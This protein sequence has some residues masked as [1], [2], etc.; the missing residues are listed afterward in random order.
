MSVDIAAQV[1]DLVKSQNPAAEAEVTVDTTDLALTRFANSFIHQ[2]VAEATTTVR[3]RL[4]ADGRTAA[5]TTTIVDTQG[6]HGLV[7]RTVAAARLAPPDPQW[8]GLAPP[9]STLPLPPVDEATAQA[10][11][12]ARAAR[13][14]DFVAAADGLE[15]AGYCSTLRLATAFANSAGMSAE[16]VSALAAMDAI[17]RAGIGRRG[18]PA[19]QLTTVRSGRRPAGRS[20][21]DQGP[22][23]PATAGAAARPLRGGARTDRGRRSAENLAFYAFNGKAVNERRSFIE[24]GDGPVRPGAVHRGR[25]VRP[26]R[27]RLRLRRGGH[28]QAAADV[29]RRRPQRRPW[30]TTAAARRRPVPPRPVT[31]CQARPRSERSRPTCTCCPPATRPTPGEVDGP[32]ADSSVAA[33]VGQVS[34]GLLVSD[35]WYTRVLDPRTLVITGL[36]RNGV[37]LIEDGV[38]TQPVQNLRF[39]QSY[40]QALA[41]GGVLGIGSHSVGLPSGWDVLAYP[42]TGAASGL[43]ELHRQRLGLRLLSGFAGRSLNRPPLALRAL[44]GSA[45]VCA[46]HCASAPGGDDP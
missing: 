21:G 25:S 44:T 22:G 41:P 43:V 34:R 18:I 39:T 24:V 28:A 26:V 11:P 14:R 2:N 45:T 27:T 4:H 38:V 29:R 9:A 6:L 33:L 20:R 31:P 12:A 16:A 15:T 19:R 17:A 32:A 36:T 46:R 5:G 8:P 10:D 7:E 37:W 1:L 23:Q 13:V 42:G 35:F 3:L 30:R 40:P